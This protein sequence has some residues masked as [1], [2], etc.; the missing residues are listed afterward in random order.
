M[1]SD[2][3]RDQ[4][5]HLLAHVAAVAVLQ[6]CH[7][8]AQRVLLQHAPPVKGRDLEADMHG[9]TNRASRFVFLGD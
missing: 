7:Q 8:R 4:G 6:H 2:G 5:H 3:V 1:S 9:A